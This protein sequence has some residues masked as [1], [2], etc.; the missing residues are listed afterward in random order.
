ME[1]GYSFQTSDCKNCPHSKK[2]ITGKTAPNKRIHH[3]VSNPMFAKQKSFQQ[4]E[5]FQQK[6]KI[7]WIIEQVNAHLKNFR[8]FDFLVELDF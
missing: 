3:R 8:V 6:L 5:G 2:C 1:I 4:S 7:R